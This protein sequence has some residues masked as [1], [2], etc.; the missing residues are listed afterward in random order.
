MSKCWQQARVVSSLWEDGAERQA[1]FGR[2]KYL[3]RLNSVLTGR[4]RLGQQML[5]IIL[6]GYPSLEAA[7]QAVRERLPIL[8]KME[9]HTAD[10]TATGGR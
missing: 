3:D 1:S 5:E 7:E 4:R 10:L 2:S 8:I 9:T 6:S